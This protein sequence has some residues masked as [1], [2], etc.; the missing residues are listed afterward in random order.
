MRALSFLAVAAF[1]AMFLYGNPVAK[2]A[3]SADASVLEQSDYSLTRN[4]G[5][6]SRL[7]VWQIVR[8]SFLSRA[9]GGADARPHT[10]AQPQP[11]LW[12]VTGSVLNVRSGPSIVHE[13]IGKLRRGQ[14][15]EVLG[16][17]T[18]DWATIRLASG[19]TGFVS[20]DYLSP[21]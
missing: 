7:A 3:S 21:M 11:E 12:K 18:G 2:L 1:G 14:E 15:A 5:T 20:A 8:T 9:L 16:G 13:I 19:D 17:I 6:G 10:V 4:E